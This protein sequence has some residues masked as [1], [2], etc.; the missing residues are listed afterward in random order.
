[1]VSRVVGVGNP[2]QVLNN[3]LVKTDQGRI[4][5]SSTNLE[6]GV[7]TWIGGKIEEEGSLT[8][9]AKLINEYINNLPSD[10]VTISTQ[11]TVLNLESE[12]YHTN[13]RGLSA[14]DFPLI[15][16]VADEPYAKI[17]STELR[18]ALS[19]T[20][21]SAA[22]NETQPEISGI[23]FNFDEDK[24]RVAATDRYRLAERVA[25]LKEA[26]KAQR[27]V[28]IPA[29]TIGELYKILSTGKGT[30]EVYFSESQVL[31]KFEETELISRLIDGQYPPYKEIIPKEFQ[32]TITADREQLVH[33]LKA[34]ALFASDSYN[35]H[36]LAVPGEGLKV[37]A[38]SVAAGENTTLIKA[39]V[40]GSENNAIFNYRYILDCLN[41]LKEKNVVI[42]LI[43][44]RSPAMLMA[45]G[46]D[47]YLYIVMPIIL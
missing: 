18:D 5:L 17:D 46:R 38:S 6:I 44:D 4:K 15:P 23:Y 39:E 41:N 28:I 42:K 21:W 24:V 9:P 45:D 37:T 47:N 36:M 1:V 19:E 43:S 25:V 26:V 40:H 29:R 10:V 20:I 14:D 8:V 12:N 33:A 31:F 13:I 2:L 3:I 16:Q 30:V 27:E 32:T 7:N 11:E 35:I 22:N 34:A